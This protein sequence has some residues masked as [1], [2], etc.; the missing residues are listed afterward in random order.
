MDT[1]SDP[2][3]IAAIRNCLDSLPPDQSAISHLVTYLDRL[4]ADPS[5]TE[6]EVQDVDAVVR[7]VL[8]ERKID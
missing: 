4:R 2:K 3:I 6:T 1:P 8:A 5:W 7:R